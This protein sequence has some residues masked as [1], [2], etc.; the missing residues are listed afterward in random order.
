LKLATDDDKRTEARCYLGLD[1]VLKGR[2]H[3]A[4]VHFRWVTEHGNVRFI[5]YVI[6]VTEIE[7]LESA[8]K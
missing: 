5:E 4:L 2:K 3:E 8:S 1:Q 6:A 7:R